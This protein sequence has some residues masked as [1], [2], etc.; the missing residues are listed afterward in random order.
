MLDVSWPTGEPA[1]GRGGRA[2]AASARHE[3]GSQSK[4]DAY[5]LIAHI[6]FLIGHVA[7][8]VCVFF[9]RSVG[10]YRTCSSSSDFCLQSAR[11]GRSV[12]DSALGSC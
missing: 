7:F 5:I 4:L 9:L 8:L 12:H 10:H 1:G 2:A 11:S 6:K 3:T